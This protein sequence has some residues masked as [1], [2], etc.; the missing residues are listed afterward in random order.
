MIPRPVVLFSVTADWKNKLAVGRIFEPCFG[1]VVADK[2]I[3]SAWRAVCN[4]DCFAK[5]LKN[6]CVIITASS[7]PQPEGGDI[8]DSREC[9]PT[10]VRFE[11]YAQPENPSCAHRE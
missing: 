9:L 6:S 4:S 10:A 8:E 7:S 1:L 2:S 5:H 11:Q 3:L